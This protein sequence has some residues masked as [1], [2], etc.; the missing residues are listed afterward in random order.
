MPWL[1]QEKPEGVLCELWQQALAKSGAKTVDIAAGLADVLAVKDAVEVL[2]TKKAAH[3]AGSCW[4][5]VAVSEIEGEQLIR[6]ICCPLLKN[7][8]EPDILAEPHGTR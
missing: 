3:L 6:P 2:N 7:Y 4:G 5:K 8:A 1:P